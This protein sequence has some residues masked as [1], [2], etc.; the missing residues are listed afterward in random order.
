MGVFGTLVGFGVGEG[1]KFNVIVPG[2][3][4][5]CKELTLLSA[6]CDVVVSTFKLAV[7]LVVVET[8]VRGNWASI[9]RPDGGLALSAGDNPKTMVILPLVLASAI[10]VTCTTVFKAVEVVTSP[11]RRTLAG[12]NT[13]SARANDTALAAE[14]NIKFTV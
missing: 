5:T 12:S 10:L 2:T 1:T 13:T 6:T 8:V 9:N 3:T 4:I 7:S 11:D 14:S